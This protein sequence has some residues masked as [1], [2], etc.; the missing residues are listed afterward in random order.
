V[1]YYEVGRLS[2]KY[3]QRVLGGTKP[4]DLPVESISRF[5]LAVNLRTA[6]ELN[7]T[8][9]PALLILADEVIR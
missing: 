8:I 7:L 1:N 5:V 6:R 9:P 3:V 2:S 4:R